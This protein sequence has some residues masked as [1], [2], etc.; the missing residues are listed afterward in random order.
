VIFVQADHGALIP[1]IDEVCRKGVQV[2]PD[3]IHVL[4][5]VAGFTKKVRAT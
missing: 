3:R 2:A 4:E 1:A 5:P